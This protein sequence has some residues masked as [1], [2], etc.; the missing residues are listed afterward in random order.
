VADDVTGFDLAEGANIT[1]VKTIIA[2]TRGDLA[3]YEIAAAGAGGGGALTQIAD[4]TLGAAAASF[5]FTSISGSYTHLLL[6][7]YLR[8][9][10]VANAVNPRLL[11]NNDSA[12]NYDSQYWLATNTTLAAAQSLAATSGLIGDVAAASAAAGLFGPVE[13]LIPNYAATSGNKAAQ[14]RATLKY[15]TVSNNFQVMFTDIHWRSSAAITRVTLFP[16]AGNWEVSS[17]VS[18]YGVT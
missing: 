8:G 4:T 1:I 3:S 12:A 7:C 10:T 16:G 18:L 6:L 11:F 13:I 9:T 2:G 5:D 14:T 17:R 15:G